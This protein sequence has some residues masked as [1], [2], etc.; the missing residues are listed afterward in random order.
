[1]FAQAGRRSLP[2]LAL[3]AHVAGRAHHGFGHGPHHLGHGWGRWGHGGFGHPGLGPWLRDF[4]PFG[5]PGA[6]RRGRGDVRLAVLGILAE[7][8]MH[9][10]QL[11]REIAQR[12]QG[13]W[14][15]SPG[16]VYPT[17]SQLE[18]E[19]LVRA[20]QSGGRRIFH[21]T[22]DG[23]A[24]VTGRADE[25][26]ALWTSD[27]AGWEQAGDFAGLVMQVGA[28]AMQVASAG[29]DDQRER[30]AELL[31]QTRRSLYRLLA[32]DDRDDD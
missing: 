24:E 21:L 5:G 4:A 28:A 27:E 11:I 19:G 20:E 9:G 3:A 7:Q 16:S 26:A 22:D 13:T 32:D 12:S 25:F 17:L 6:P 2:F 23:R 29:T 8:P 14:R 18:D 15:V 10:Y 30:A 1:M 31:E